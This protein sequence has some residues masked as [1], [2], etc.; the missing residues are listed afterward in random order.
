MDPIYLD[1]NATTPVAPEVAA[2]M[3]PVL[4][5]IFGNPSSPH[6]FGVD[7]KDAVDHARGQVSALIGAEPDQVIFTGCATES[8]NIA[9]LGA[10]VMQGG[11]GHIIT[12]AVEHPAVLEVCVFCRRHGWDVTVVPVMSDGRVDPG[13]IRTAMRDDTRLVS[14][15]HANNEVG[16]IQPITEISEIIRGQGILFHVDAAQSTGKIPVNVD[17]LGADLLT[18]AAHKFYGPKGIGALYI[19]PGTAVA[20]IAFGASHE[21]GIRPGTE[22]VHN[23]VGL[24]AAAELAMVDPGGRIRHM[25]ETRDGLWE[26]LRDGC[27]DLRRNGSTDYCLPNTLS[28]GVRGCTATDIMNEI[29]EVAI[30]AGAACHSPDDINV[31][32][33]LEAMDVPAEYAH[34]T[35]RISTGIMTTMDQVDRAAALIIDAV[36]RLRKKDL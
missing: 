10:T 34:G 26:R 35:L 5:K 6:W 32:H 29:P 19:R 33:V 17:D 13:V 15:M 31:S 36:K 8:N 24:G 11:K 3:I 16:A 7:A 18:I 28:V 4:T 21:R 25:A 27:G 23:I 9:I 20:G 2:T 1:Y 22:N 30:S 14:I 12:S